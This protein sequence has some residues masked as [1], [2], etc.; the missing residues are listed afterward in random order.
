[1]VAAAAG[2]GKAGVFVSLV[3]VAEQRREEEQVAEAAVPHQQQR[4]AVQRLALIFV[5]VAVRAG[6]VD[7][8]AVGGQKLRDRPVREEDRLARGYRRAPHVG[9]AFERY[10]LHR[11]SARPGGFH[12][13]RE[14]ALF[15]QRKGRGQRR[16]GG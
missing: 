2:D 14:A 11:A 5:V 6:D 4:A 15:S 16:T 1:V 13:L 3:Q 10:D 12:P 7:G 8:V 9:A